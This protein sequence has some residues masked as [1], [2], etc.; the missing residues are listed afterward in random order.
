MPV[1]RSTQIVTGEI[2][3]AYDLIQQSC[4]RHISHEGHFLP[5]PG[6]A[7]SRNEPAHRWFCCRRRRR[8]PWLKFTRPLRS[9]LL[10]HAPARPSHF[11][12]SLTIIQA[13]FAS[14]TVDLSHINSWLKVVSVLINFAKSSN[15][16]SRRP[17]LGWIRLHFWGSQCRQVVVRSTKK[18][19]VQSY[20]AI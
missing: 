3:R 17:T 1:A 10:V 19:P 6:P 5:S 11:S 4:K 15:R 2:F 12:V 14:T 13:N 9:N 8:V 20:L 7:P 16:S 18:S